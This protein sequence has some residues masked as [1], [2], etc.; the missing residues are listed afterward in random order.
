MEAKTDLLRIANETHPRLLMLRRCARAGSAPLPTAEIPF[1]VVHVHLDTRDAM[2]AN[3]VNTVC[4]RLGTEIERITGA[5]VGLR[6]LS[7]YADQRLF[8][9]RCR[10]IPSARRKR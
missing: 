1:L 8:R 7:N 3:L 10:V 9:A 2:G 4:E 5:R 6:I